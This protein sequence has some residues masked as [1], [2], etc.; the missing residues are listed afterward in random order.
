MRIQNAFQPMVDL[1]G[2]KSDSQGESVAA[3]A[4]RQLKQSD[5][6]NLGAAVKLL[7]D[8]ESLGT[9]NVR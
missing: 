1:K 6:E 5:A 8:S 4:Q 9:Q 7:N 2:E 3:E